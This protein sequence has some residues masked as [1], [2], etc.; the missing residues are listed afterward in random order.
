[1]TVI[2][3]ERVPGKLKGELTRWMLEVTEGV[4]VN[5]LSATVRAHLWDLVRRQGRPRTAAVL[6]Y[7]SAADQGFTIEYHGQPTHQVVDF[8]G[9][10][11]LRLPD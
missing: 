10:Q 5:R 9:L 3:L 8:E 6:L 4:F 1:M 2:V 7:T 11:L